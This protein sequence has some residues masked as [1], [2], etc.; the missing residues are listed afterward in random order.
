MNSKILFQ[1]ALSDISPWLVE[2]VE[3][4]T[5]E[6]GTKE[7][8]LRLDFPA[9]STFLNESGEPCKAHDTSDHTWRP[10]SLAFKFAEAKKISTS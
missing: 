2:S 9:G 4:K 10:R 6:D 8:H 5:S 3:F 7:L 1:L